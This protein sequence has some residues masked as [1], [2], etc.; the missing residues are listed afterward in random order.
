MYKKLSQKLAF[1]HLAY[2]K[3]VCGVP[4]FLLPLLHQKIFPSFCFF[5]DFLDQK[6]IPK[7]AFSSDIW[8][9]QWKRNCVTFT[10]FLT[11]KTVERKIFPKYFLFQEMTLKWV[12]PA[13]FLSR[14]IMTKYGIS[15][16]HS[17]A[18]MS[19]KILTCLQCKEQEDKV[20]ESVIKRMQVFELRHQIVLRFLVPSESN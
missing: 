11:Q 9:Q 4:S 12:I 10:I 18:F 13:N 6:I 19:Q 16:T 20:G 17:I 1:C 3:K 15:S 2:I 8:Q 5:E 7:G 14:K